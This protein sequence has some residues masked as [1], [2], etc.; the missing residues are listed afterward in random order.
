MHWDVLAFEG[1]YTTVHKFG[2][3]F[4][5]KKLIVLF[6]KGTFH[7][8]VSIYLYSTYKTAKRLTKVLHRDKKN[9]KIITITQLKKGLALYNYLIDIKNIRETKNINPWKLSK[10]RDL[11]DGKWQ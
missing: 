4:Y 11:I 1:F 5:F 2:F 9:I 3:S 8:Q 7:F 10:K 6:S